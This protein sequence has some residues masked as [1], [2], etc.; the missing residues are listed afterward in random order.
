[1]DKLLQDLRFALRSVV[2]QP[3]FAITAIVTLALGIGA[4]TAIFTV[5]NAV[6]L[7][8]LS[9]V[10]P[11]RIVAI[12]NLWT[13][14]GRR[15]STVSAPDFHDWQVQSRSFQAMA[16]YTGWET[17][18]TVGPTADYAN[19]YRVTPQFFDVLRM[20]TAVGR[21]PT[22]EEQKP[23]GALTAVITDAF[24][25]RQFDAQPRAIGSTVKV[26]DQIF[27]IVGILAAGY[28]FPARADVYLPSWITP[29]TKSR[30]GHNYRAI[31]RLADGVTVDQARG[32]MT[33]IA[34][35]LEAE[36]PNTNTG[37]LTDVFPLQEL[38]VGSTRQTLYLL[39][40]AVALV[41]LI[42]CANVAN[43]LLSRSTVRQREMVVRAAVGAGRAR[44][45]RQL[46]T[47]AAVFGLAAAVLGGWLARLAMGGLMALAPANLPRLNEVHV[48]G[49]AFGFAVVIAL[50]ASI[51]FGLAPA[52]QASRIELVEGLRQGGKGSS[53]GAR[54][55][56]ARN[57]FVVA[58]IALAVVLV[59]GAALLARSLATLAAVDLGFAP[60]HLLVLSTAVPAQNVEQ[61]QHATAFYRDLLP[62]LRALPG[63]TA[64]AG[65]MGAPPDP[66]SNG[67]YWIEGG[68]GLADTGVQAP[69]A[70][71]NVV[72]PDYF[73][74]MRIPL[75]EGRDIRD[76]DTRDAPFVAVVNESLARAAFPGQSPI[77]RW[78]QCGLDSLE[79][80][81][82]VGVVGDVRTS[83]PSLPPEPEIY[84]AYQQHPGPSTE[85]TL[86][87][88]TAVAD[89]LSLAETIRRKITDRN[90]DVPMK[91]AT[92]ESSLGTATAAPR[93]QTFLLIV[94]AGVALVL[95]L[96]GVYGVMAY[97][98]SQR[99]PELGV[100]I[101]LGAT[102]ANISGLIFGAGAKLAAAGLAIGLVLALTFGRLLQSMLFGVTPRDP[103]VL[104]LVMLTVALATFAACYVPV[105]RAVRV[106][107]MDALRT[108]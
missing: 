21:L 102:P 20:R 92:M 56:W 58:E 2:R 33:G 83:G 82:I 105:R 1:M 51:V 38:V 79:H 45:V 101:A 106:D 30:S 43:L 10:N 40:A 17:S 44:L 36:Y 27:T 24:W 64:A 50:I 32:E 77:G 99:V 16:Y 5:V 69:Q 3:A 4:T 97:S 29:E 25:K 9:F 70:I 28:P 31:A 90:P 46:L 86:V 72:T 85:L 52:L 19:V 26:D 54:R 104:A 68:P 34:R 6:L 94:F 65:A 103:L 15:G 66:R 95:A 57:A 23:G 59:M 61:A 14:T 91:A 35:R 84:M 41:L 60:E 47:E 107:P 18:V 67:G 93:F 98:V 37:K 13:K 88:R 12:A 53:V 89:P 74:T 22:A 42:A 87:V 55:G 63:V 108:E 76:S 73:R 81:T 100:R 11:D 75:E 8:P 80:M 7:R 78:I 71:F 62:E 96:A 48:D 39:L 49:T